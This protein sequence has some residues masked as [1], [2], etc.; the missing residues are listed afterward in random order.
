MSSILIPVDFSLPCHNAYRFSLHLAEALKL[1]VVLAHYSS[2]SID[3]GQPLIFAGDG[4]LQGSHIERLRSFARSTAEG[5]D[6]PLAEPASGTKVTY[7]SEIVFSVAATIIDRAAQK[8]IAMVVM[9][10]RSSKKILGKWLGSTSTT[11]SESSNR[12]VYIIPDGVRFHPFRKVVIANNNL[13]ANA[14]PLHQIDALASMYKAYIHFVHVEWPNQYGPLRFVPWKLMEKLVDQEPAKYPF[15][16]VTVEKEDITEGLL[17][18]AAK[19]DADLIVVV[20]NVRNRWRAFLH[21]SL[22]Q[23]LALRA[24]RPVLVLHTEDSV[25]EARLLK[26]SAKKEN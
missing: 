8:D 16:V 24:N 9:A 13:A 3:P 11:V 21:A 6:Y 10:P 5:I 14:Y 2:G 7:E 19:I 18:Y 25:T 20:N 1:N 12:P 15:D 17:E 23:D 22:T 26:D 4:S